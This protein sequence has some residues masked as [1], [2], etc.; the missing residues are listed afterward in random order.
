MAS[1]RE[2]TVVVAEFLDLLA[3]GEL[4]RAAD[5]LS[6]DVLYTNVSLP[7][8]RGRERVGGALKRTLGRPGAGFEV[9]THTSAADGSVVLTE[10]TDVLI[11]RRL[12]VQI[13]VYGR[14]EVRDDL[15]T[16]WRDSFDWLNLTLALLR[17]LAGAVLP[18]LAAKPPS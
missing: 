3:A 15:I 4:D 9:Y 18:A 8:M 17:G 1:A 6:A 14:F 5:L 13:W 16:V 7:Q 2:P 10:R 11:Y 12:R